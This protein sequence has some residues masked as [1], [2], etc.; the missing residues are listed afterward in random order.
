M[1]II[2]L[3]LCCPLF[4]FGQNFKGKVKEVNSHQGI[5]YV[6][7]GIIGKNI[8]TVSDEV[9]NFELSTAA[10]QTTDT[11]QFSMIGYKS[12]IFT[13]QEL[14]DFY[15]Q[16]KIV[17]LEKQA[18]D[19]TEIVV[20]PKDYKTKI[21]GNTT[22]NKAMSAGYETNNLGYELG[23]RMK[24]KK[25]PTYIEQIRINVAKCTYDSIFY[26]LNI[27]EM[28]GKTPGENILKE[29]IYLS[30][31]KEDIEDSIIL[32]LSD[33]GVYVEDDFLV[34]LELVNDLGVRGLYFCAGVFNN[35]TYYRETS[36]GA[37]GSVPIGIGIS[38]KIRQEQ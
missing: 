21:V 8:G 9:G 16:E 33:K 12:R 37:W 28:K 17:T 23:V 32:D 24:I 20:I 5:S 11:I 1:K 15:K 38:A 30:F 29:P 10:A 35:K 3:L 14:T 36:Q 18:Y 13:V 27:Y 2:V 19:L 4:L 6:N 7:I 25:R 31:A 22:N 34:S 26:R